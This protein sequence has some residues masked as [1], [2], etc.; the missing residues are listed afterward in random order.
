MP[1]RSMLR[2]L[3]QAHYYREMML[4][5]QGRTMRDLAREAGVGRPYFSRMVRLGFLAP[6]IVKAVLRDRHPPE[7]TAK[8]LSL[9]IKLPSAWD[10]QKSALG[11]V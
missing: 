8:R 4:D 7:L 9:H 11:I 2:L 5:G 6:D 3:A 1:D 10:K